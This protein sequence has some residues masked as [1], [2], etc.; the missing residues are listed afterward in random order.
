MDDL[1]RSNTLL[2]LE[3]PVW[4]SIDP[5]WRQTENDKFPAK[6]QDM[7]GTA[8]TK[9][10]IVTIEDKELKGVVVVLN[11]KNL[12]DVK[13]L[14]KLVAELHCNGYENTFAKYIPFR[15]PTVVKDILDTLNYSD[16]ESGSV[17]NA[18]SIDGES[19]VFV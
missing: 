8:V 13:L 16:E 7:K 10:D 9:D 1:Y 2:G 18:E 11:M 3:L 15:D 19:W 6:L 5:I 4:P 14:Y 12:S 17:S